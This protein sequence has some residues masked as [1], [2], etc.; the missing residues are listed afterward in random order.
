MSTPFMFTRP[1]HVVHL[2]I[3][4]CIA[5]TLMSMLETV[6]LGRSKR[7]TAGNR[8]VSQLF[9]ECFTC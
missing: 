3:Q 7:A 9:W 2:T 5:V 8:Y 6:A 4:T 1:S